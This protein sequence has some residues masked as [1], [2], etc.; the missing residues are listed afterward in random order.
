[1]RLR[2]YLLAGFTSA[3][4][5]MLTGRASFAFNIIP[6]QPGATSNWRPVSPYLIDDLEGLMEG[7]TEVDKTL[8]TEPIPQGGTWLF[9]ATLN[10]WALSSE[11][12]IGG[13][14]FQTAQQELRGNFEIVNYLACG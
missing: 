12:G 6:P 8:W 14:N 1:M 2:Q 5:V 7:V 10:L 3:L 13:W 9:S 11:R 4:T